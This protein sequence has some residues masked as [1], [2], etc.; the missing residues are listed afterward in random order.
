LTQ[1]DFKASLSKG[2]T[3]DIFRD[4]TM[5]EPSRLDQI[6]AILA[7]VAQ[8]QQQG[9]AES[10]ALINANAQGLTETR[11]LIEANAQGL[12][13]TQ[14]RLDQTQAICDSNARAIAEA[15]QEREEGFRE[16]KALIDSNARAIEANSAAIAAGR[17]ETD[18]VR[19][20]L[21]NAVQMIIDLGTHF[22]E[23]I[24]AD[25]AERLALSADVRSLVQTLRERFGGNGHGQH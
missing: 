20:D 6:E 24:E 14:A 4:N 9:F 23:Q 1:T 22:G 3:P 19:A 16:T 13:A 15:K 18:A 7:T 10:R 5:T 12:A 2:Y 21:R 11:A 25:R 17:L 8:Q